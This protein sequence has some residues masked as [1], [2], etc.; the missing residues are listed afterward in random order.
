MSKDDN[1]VELYR[2]FR[3]KNFKQVIGQEDA[4]RQLT[5][6]LKNDRLP[7]ALL[8]SGGSGVGKTTIARILKNKLGCTD[9][10]FCEI[11][12]AEDRG[13]DMIREMNSRMGLSPMG[14]TCRMWLLDEAHQMSKRAGG[15]AQTALLKVLEDVPKH[16][17]IILCTTDPAKLLPT[18]RTRCTEIKLKPLL[19]KDLDALIRSVPDCPKLSDA[20]VK[21]IAEVADGS[22]RKAL[23][24]LHQVM[25]LETEQEQLEAVQRSDTKRQAIELA[26]AM[27]D[28]NKKW[29]EIAAIITGIEDEAE[30][31]RRLV[32]AY[33]S[34]VLAK[35]TGKKAELA[36]L[37]MF[38]FRDSKIVFDNPGKGG[39]LFMANEVA[40]NRK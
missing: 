11:N 14:G 15:D 34:S 39:L 12:A 28:P 30:G 20:V 10:D 7:H 29:P 19:A 6:M 38:N 32:F 16:V 40:S 35:A 22:A 3:P 26:R 25:G 13:I 9:G 23:V 8:F 36:S 1:A 2:K 33:A 37:V 4:V 27:M 18:I 31:I 5:E 21:Q 17:Y 24:L